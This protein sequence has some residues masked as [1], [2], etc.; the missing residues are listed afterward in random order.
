ML[1]YLTDMLKRIGVGLYRVFIPSE[2]RE[3]GINVYR[4]I[5]RILHRG[6]P[7]YG[8]GVRCFPIFALTHSDRVICTKLVYRDNVLEETIPMENIAEWGSKKFNRMHEF[9]LGEEAPESQEEFLR[10]I[11]QTA[12]VR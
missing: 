3:E 4:D 11:R 5:G 7:R 9:I 2:S 6:P 8:S 12:Y 1:T 10:N